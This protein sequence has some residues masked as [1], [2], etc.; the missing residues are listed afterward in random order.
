MEDFELMPVAIL[1]MST[2]W[3]SLFYA[4]SSFRW[5][6]KGVDRH[7]LEILCGKFSLLASFFKSFL[8]QIISSL[9]NLENLENLKISSEEDANKYLE[10]WMV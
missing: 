1:T 3:R 2:T 9:E 6:F 10:V 5:K 7:S 8:L 4:V